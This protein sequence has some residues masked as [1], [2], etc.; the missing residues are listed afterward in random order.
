MI[1]L[2][3]A[4][5]PFAATCIAGRHPSPAEELQLFV[6]D[7]MN[8]EDL[9][10]LAIENSCWAMPCDVRPDSLLRNGSYQTCAESIGEPIEAPCCVA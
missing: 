9:N 3:K 1:C 5:G 6:T 8:V 2:E 7:L 4:L 10:N